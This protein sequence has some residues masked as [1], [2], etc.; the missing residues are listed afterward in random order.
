MSDT[1]LPYDGDLKQ[2]Q[3]NERPT[4]P[5]LSDKSYNLIKNGAM[6]ILPALGTL[7]FALAGLWGFP[8]PEKVVGTI[9]A[10][11]TFLGVVV[12]LAKRSYVNSGANGEITAEV[13]HAEHVVNLSDLKLGLTPEELAGKSLL[14]V[15]INKSNS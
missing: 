15:R 7:Y 8:E 12:L 10:V 4:Y 14:Q 3:D 13:D 1:E 6:I 11:N 5:L 2:N 9:A